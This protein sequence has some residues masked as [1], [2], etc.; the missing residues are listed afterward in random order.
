MPGSYG[1][2]YLTAGNPYVAADGTTFPALTPGTDAYA[3][4]VE[5]WNLSLISQGRA[6]STP[7]GVM[8]LDN[9]RFALGRAGYTGPTDPASLA[10]AYQ[11][12][13]SPPQPVPSPGTAPVQAS[14]SVGGLSLSGGLQGLPRPLLYAGL[15]FVAYELLFSHRRRLL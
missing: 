13:Q 11:M 15:A 12:L 10:S 3:N 1:D 14:A 7:H 9:V 4:Q 6:I 2:Q 5:Q 8:S